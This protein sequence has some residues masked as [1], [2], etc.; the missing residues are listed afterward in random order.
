MRKTYLLLSSLIFCA[1]FVTDVHAG[2]HQETVTPV[3]PQVMVPTTSKDK[4]GNTL[5]KTMAYVKTLQVK[6]G[7]L[8]VSLDYIQ[9]FFGEAAVKA[10]RQDHPLEKEDYPMPYYMGLSRIL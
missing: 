5:E 8:I 7:K 2:S 4:H 6:N 3:P 9:W 10:Y 1:L